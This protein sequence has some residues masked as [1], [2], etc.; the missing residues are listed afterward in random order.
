MEKKHPTDKERKQKPT[1][2]VTKRENID[3]EWKNQLTR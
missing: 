1:H 2:K 3:K